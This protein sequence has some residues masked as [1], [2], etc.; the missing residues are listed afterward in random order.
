M[1]KKIYSVEDVAKFLKVHRAINSG[2]LG[3]FRVGKRLLVTDE[4]LSAFIEAGK[5]Q[6]TR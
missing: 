3:A 1:P 6:V 2:K 4:Q 5:T